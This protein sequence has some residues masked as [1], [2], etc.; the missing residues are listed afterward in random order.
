MKTIPCE[1]CGSTQHQFLF[2]GRD[3]IF[4]T[5]GVFQVVKCRA[6]EAIFINPQPERETLKAYY[7]KSYHKTHESRY[8]EYSW[9]RK[10]ILEEYFGYGTPSETCKGLGLLE[11]AVFLPLKIRYRKSIPFVEKGRLLDIGCGNGT[12]LFRLKAMGWETYGVEIDEEAV[13]S[14]RSRGWPW[15]LGSPSRN[16]F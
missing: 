11:K 1:V 14:A 3:R 2:E 5:P 16:R 10:K 4:G 8:L 7:P 6:C 15:A 9:L 13:K 12:E